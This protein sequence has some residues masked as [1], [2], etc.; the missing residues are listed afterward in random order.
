MWLKNLKRC[1]ESKQTDS[2]KNPHTIGYFMKLNA[3]IVHDTF[4]ECL[5]NTGEPTEDHKLGRAVSMTVG[6]HPGRLKSKEQ[7]ISE[8]L[9][10]LPKE[11]QKEGGGMS[12]LNMC[13]DKSGDQ[14]A[15]QKTADE[16]VALG[17]AS[18][19]L[20]FLMPKEMWSS[21]PGGVPYLVVN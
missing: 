12:F 16:L 8:M 19:K 6:F 13:Q 14:W 10:D 11:F 4:L 7:L 18:G 21:L 17:I 20:S 15:E 1:W 3:K 2:Y 9:K 5:F